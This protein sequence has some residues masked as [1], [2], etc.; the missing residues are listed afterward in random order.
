[1]MDLCI[2]A[3]M[4]FSSGIGTYIREIV[5][6][7]KNA[8]RVILLV[9]GHHEW[10]QGFEQ[11]QFCTPVYSAREQLQYPSKIPTCDLFWSPHYNVPLL[12]IKAKKK[13]VTIHDVCHLVYGSFVQRIYARFVMRRALR[14]DKVITVSQ[15]SKREIE[16]R[17][18]KRNLEVIPIGV[19]L[20]QFWQRDF[21]KTV[22]DKYSL[23]KT[24]AL[25]VG[26]TKM[27]KNL[28]GVKRACEKI[29][30]ELVAVGQGLK[31][32]EAHDLPVLYSMAEVFVFPSF[33]EGFGL[34]PLEAMACK[35]PTAVSLAA[36]IPEVC[37]DASVYFDPNDAEGM[38]KAIQ[39]AREKK[40]LGKGLERVKQFSWKSAAER[41]MQVF[42]EIVRA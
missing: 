4:A 18:G 1:M 2:D 35:C 5:P 17:F 21:S 22:R 7:F 11:I 30:L 15:F 23:P 32:V 13:G 6:F 16:K 24:F 36:S 3:R 29:K 37:G 39:K 19:N 38:A 28:E 27:H 8:F 31:E 20:Q 10:C 41:H 33:Y 12:S 40:L 34:P 14:S 42:Q 9:D 25:F 26:S